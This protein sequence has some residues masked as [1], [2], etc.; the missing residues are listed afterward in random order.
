MS[1]IRYERYFNV[2]YYPRRIE[3]KA[4]SSVPT[5]CNRLIAVITDRRVV[6]KQLLVRFSRYLNIERR[7]W[8]ATA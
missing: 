6:G 2:Y 1:N 7:F 3:Y 8:L 5:T 4:T